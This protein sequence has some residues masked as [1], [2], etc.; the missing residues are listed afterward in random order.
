MVTV[1]DHLPGAVWRPVSYIGEAGPFTSRPRGWVLHVVVGDGSPFQTFQ[2][3]KSP[4]RRFS[5]LWVSKAG[6]IEQYQLLSR[7]SWAQGQGNGTWWSVETEGFPDEALTDRQIRALAHIHKTLGAPNEIATTPSGSGIGT[8][9]MGG[10]AWGGHSC[11]G[12]IRAGQRAA[13]I[14][15]ATA[16]DQ[17]KGEEDV[18]V[19]FTRAGDT[20]PQPAYELHAAIIDGKTV[21]LPRHVSAAEYNERVAAGEA[22]KIRTLPRADEAWTLL[23]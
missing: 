1:P 3:A 17:P 15:A 9:Q 18:T 12:T 19:L 7:K 22:V 4:D 6:S 13:I 11:P 5:H 8:H 2:T 23:P 16:L 21:T 14:Q 10:L 20:A